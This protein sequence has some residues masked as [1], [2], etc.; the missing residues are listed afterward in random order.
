MRSATVCRLLLVCVAVAAG[1]TGAPLRAFDEARLSFEVAFKGQTSS[2]RELAL[3]VLPAE[4]LEIEARPRGDGAQAGGRFVLEA[5]A[6]AVS[7]ASGSRA[8]RAWTWQAPTSAGPYE[9]TVRSP[10]GES[11]T[12]RAFVMVPA[13]RREGDLLEGYRLGAYPNSPFRG[14]ESYRSP[15]GFV[16]VTPELESL[17]ISPHFTLGQFLCKQAGPYPKFVVLRESLALKLEGLL[18]ATRRAGWDAETFHVMSGYR[19]PHYNRAIGNVKNSRHLYGDAADIFVDVAPQDGWM[20]DLDGDGKIGVGDVDALREVFE[21]ATQAPWYAPFVGGL[22]RYRAN[23]VRGPFL[24]VDARGYRA[25]W[26]G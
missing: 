6:G 9:L 19:T 4:S 21:G 15:R 26:E 3:F 11:M 1:A 7:P 13:S 24:H 14:L 23:E 8:G 12:L 18:A 20:D 25:R 22:G 5:A 17:R 10:E 2:Y 16:R